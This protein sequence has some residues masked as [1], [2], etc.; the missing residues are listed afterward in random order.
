MVN[1]KIRHGWVQGQKHRR[2]RITQVVG[3]GAVGGVGG[4]WW[5]IQ[6]VVGDG[7]G[8]DEGR[9]GQGRAVLWQDYGSTMAGLW[10]GSSSCI[11]QP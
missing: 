2:G 10:Q 6:V 1:W 9:E 8:S 11:P 4:W 3:R 7:G 5:S